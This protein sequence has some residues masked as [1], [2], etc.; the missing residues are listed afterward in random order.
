MSVQQQMMPRQARQSP[1]GTKTNS[2]RQAFNNAPVSLNASPSSRVNIKRQNMIVIIRSLPMKVYENDC[3]HYSI[4]E[5][6]VQDT[7]SDDGVFLFEG[8]LCIIT[9]KPPCLYGRI[10]TKLN[11]RVYTQEVFDKWKA[12][13]RN[14]L[15]LW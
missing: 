12:T 9:L 3:L 5:G 1:T 6:R 2:H 10:G 4:Y 8:E 13:S 14:L 15:S 7:I 11:H